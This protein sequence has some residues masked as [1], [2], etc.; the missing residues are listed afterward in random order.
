MKSLVQFCVL[1]LFVGSV[2]PCAAAPSLID[3]YRK[4]LSADPQN[5]MLRY[6]LGIALLNQGETLLAVKAFRKAYQQRASDPEINFNLAIAYTR[7][8]D[9][10]SALI[11][12]DQA[13]ASG[14]GEQ[15]EIYL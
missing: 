1:I 12:L 7:L 2:L 14:A 4:A 9:P 8:K 13:L 15:P 5:Q 10:D 3:H 11:Y 6:H